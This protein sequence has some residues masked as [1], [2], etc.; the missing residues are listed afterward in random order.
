[1]NRGV[2]AGSLLLSLAGWMANL[3][4]QEA[5]WHPAEEVAGSA[6]SYHTPAADLGRPE[7]IPPP[8]VAPYALPPITTPPVLPVGYDA[9]AT[10]DSPA[11]LP[12]FLQPAALTTPATIIAVSAPAEEGAPPPV[13]EPPGEA[14]EFAVERHGGPRRNGLPR[15]VPG[16]ATAAPPGFVKP[17]AASIPLTQEVPTLP[18]HVPT[19]SVPDNA[20]S[21]NTWM[22]PQG[23]PWSPS[24]PTFNPWQQTPEWAQSESEETG[25]PLHAH[26]YG[27]AE[28]LLWWLK[29]E[30]TPVLLT[31]SSPSDFGVL[32][33]PTTRVLFGGSDI[34][35]GARSGGRF[36]VGYWFDCDGLGIEA[37]GFFLGSKSTDITASGLPVLGRPFF[38]VNSNAQFSQLVALP[39]VTTGT[40]V[41]H[42]PSDFW[43]AELNFLCNMCCGCSSCS[44]DCWKVNLLA[45]FRYLDLDES[46]MLTENIQGLSTAPAPFTNQTITVFDRFATHNQFY[47]GQIGI[48][49]RY[50]WGKWSVD[51]RAKLGLG[52]TEQTIDIDGGQRFVAPDGTVTAAKGGLLAEPSNIGHFSRA[53]FSVVPE[54]GIN[55]GYQVTPHIRGFVGYNF[56]LWTNV[57]RPGDQI[58]TQLNVTQ[59]PNFPTNSPAS[60]LNRP[61]MPFHQTDIWAQ[62]LL[63]GVEFTF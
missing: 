6:A 15:V 49:G 53:R 25:A 52:G 60:N 17:V 20:A 1:M 43:G 29:G 56:L 27:D 34:N 38:N 8:P 40:A 14:S 51:M 9:P 41:I 26:F 50:L 58:D 7:V 45:G 28:Y 18:G 35:D 32:G 10:L 21:P 22:M 4:A 44:G 12:S 11:P 23:S 3:A 59:I 46:L 55:L 31:T 5:D 48:D 30:H 61:L 16:M 36:T 24:Q 54:V 2:W 63:V 13:A 39:G 62:G 47:G 33:A 57:V 19:P 37:S 42:A